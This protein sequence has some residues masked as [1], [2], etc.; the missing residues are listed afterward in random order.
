MSSIWWGERAQHVHTVENDEG[1]FKEVRDRHLA[2]HGAKNIDVIF[3]GNG[4]V[5]YSR[6]IHKNVGDYDVI[7]VDGASNRYLCA[8]EGLKKLKVGGMMIL[9][10]AEWYPNTAKMLRGAGLLQIDFFV[11]FQ[12]QANAL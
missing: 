11:T 5:E 10:N 7:I 6:A 12:D 1:W 4:H 8:K 9:D 3:E 2:S